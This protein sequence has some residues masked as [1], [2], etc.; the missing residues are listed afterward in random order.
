MGVASRLEVLLFPPH[1]RSSYVVGSRDRP[2][3]IRVGGRAPLPADPS[4]P[5]PTLSSTVLQSSPPPQHKSFSF[6][7]IS[8]L[9]HVAQ[10]CNLST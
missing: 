10:T 3:V 4:Y 8:S 6:S 9:A 7:E 2:Q 5:S 1:R